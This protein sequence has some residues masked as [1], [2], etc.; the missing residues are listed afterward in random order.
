MAIEI[1]EVRENSVAGRIRS[2]HRVSMRSALMV[3]VTALGIVAA[4]PD[5]V[6]L[7]R[8]ELTA[9]AVASAAPARISQQDVELM[10]Y[11]PGWTEAMVAIDEISIA[12]EPLVT[13]A[14]NS[15]AIVGN[16]IPVVNVFARQAYI[17]YNY[18]IWPIVWL[19]TS[20]G[21][22]FLGTLDVG[23]LNH[24][25][26]VTAQLFAGFVQAEANYFLYGGWNP[27]AVAATAA[28][29]AKAATKNGDTATSNATSDADHGSRATG[30]AKSGRTVAPIG[31]RGDLADR[32]TEAGTQSDTPVAAAEKTDPDA[33]DQLSADD[34]QT[35]PTE[36][37]AAGSSRTAS[38]K[39]KGAQSN[40]SSNASSATGGHKS[41]GTGHNARR[42]QPKK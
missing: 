30:L 24:W 23:Y 3:G 38:S 9:P 19:P 17:I 37:K 14:V 13:S 32:S 40:S 8:S 39:S 31:S 16:S 27:L 28:G 11:I 42:S 10:A 7:T 33:T 22:L 4:L 18:L 29:A 5:G 34:P 2:L 15:L 26:S 35:D 25:I 20:C 1:G 6:A 36:S 21:V 12:A 41:T